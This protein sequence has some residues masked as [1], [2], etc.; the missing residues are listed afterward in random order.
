[1]HRHWSLKGLLNTCSHRSFFHPQVLV[2][3][4]HSG[5]RF[6]LVSL[7]PTRRYLP[8][9]GQSYT[10]TQVVFHLHADT[11]LSLVSLTPTLSSLSPTRRYWPLIGHSVFCPHTDI[12]L[13]FIIIS[14]TH[15]Y[16]PLIG[17]YSTHTQ[18]LASYW[19]VFHPYTDTGLP[20]VSIPPTHRYWP[21]TGQ[22]STHTQILASH[23]SVL[24]PH[25]DT[26]PSL[27][28]SWEFAFNPYC[29]IWSPL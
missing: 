15:K 14:P 16:W 17:Q 4:T 23:W 12:G 7:P 3:H 18:V 5:P 20:L 8:L 11:G 9:I 27:G 24:H 2:F 22:S 26:G 25:T 13:S 6:L 29:C 21:L 19:S 10:H 28:V 1:M